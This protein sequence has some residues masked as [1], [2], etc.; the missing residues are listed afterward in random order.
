MT[1]SQ[2]YKLDLHPLFAHYVEDP[3][4]L[5]S[6]VDRFINGDCG[7]LSGEDEILG[8]MRRA[9]DGNARYA[10]YETKT[11]GRVH[12]LAK[13]PEILVMPDLVYAS[14]YGGIGGD[15]NTCDCPHCT[16][17]QEPNNNPT[18]NHGNT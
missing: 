11:C 16:A 13:N 1:S 12:I 14:E 6:V 5:L 2:P 4:E 10:V 18:T 15:L 8:F 9:I 7:D 3:A 17:A